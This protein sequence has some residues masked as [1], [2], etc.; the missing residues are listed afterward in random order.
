[1]FGKA[2]TTGESFSE[3]EDWGPPR[4]RQRGKESDAATTLM[5]LCESDVKQ[6]SFVEA[7]KNH[8]PNSKARKRLSRIPG[9]AVEVAN[10]LGSPD[11]PFSPF[12]AQN[13]HVRTKRE[14]ERERERTPILRCQLEK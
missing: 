3:D 4:K 11:R 1:M 7:E 14:G 8:L 2:T 10:F 5:T 6:S 13:A 9:D 12:S